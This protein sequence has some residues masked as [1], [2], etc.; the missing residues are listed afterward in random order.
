MPF[1]ELIYILAFAP[2]LDDIIMLNWQIYFFV[3][4]IDGLFVSNLSQEF[5]LSPAIVNLQI[6]ITADI[7]LD[8]ELLYV[9]FILPTICLNLV[10][11]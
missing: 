2:P 1:L 8:H 7:M 3:C 5:F 6:F 9:W 4:P 10:S 11:P